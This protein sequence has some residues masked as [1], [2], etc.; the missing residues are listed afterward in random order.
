MTSTTHVEL[1]DLRV[2]A[3]TRELLAGLSL[4][5]R[6]GECVGLV[7][8]SGSGK[9]LTSLALL[10]LLP[11]GL[12][13][14]A[15]LRV[16]GQDIAFGSRQHAALRGRVFGLVPQDPL[17]ALHPLRSIGAQL[18]ETLRVA[19]GLSRDA[20]QAEAEALLRRV[21]LPQ[22]RQAMAKHPHQFSGGQRQRIAIAI[23]LATQPRI[24]IADEPTSALDARI[25]RDI[26]DLL[27]ALRR[28][29]NLGLLLISHDLPLVGAYARRLLV[30]RRG[31][32]VERGDTR[33]VFAAPSH[34]YTRELLAADQLHA[35]PAP[36]VDAPVLLRAENLRMRYRGARS[37]A[38]DGISVQL[39]RG[40]GL[41]LVGESGSGKST[42]GRALLK[43]LRGASGR[44]TLDGSAL[45][46]LDAAGLRTLRRR[47]GVV[48]QDPYASLDPRF[49][50][51]QVI[52]EPL[53][54]HG[55][56]NADSQRAKALQLLEAVGMDASALDRHPHQFSGGQR[57]RI[58][59]ARAL[60]TS[61]DLLV[62]DEAVSALDAHHR[63]SILALLAK[64]K[65]E[66]GL[67]LLF[68]THD[69]AAASAVAER[70]AVLEAGRI[71]ETG[72]T[73]AVLAHPQHAHTQALVAARPAA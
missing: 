32:V 73:A 47:I 39:R 11:A 71:V 35:L 68:V 41:A 57:Q 61:P 38:L 5:L 29:E 21:Q 52:T 62:C 7:G 33:A 43:L 67:A 36:A 8:E 28:Q 31:V 1:S 3:G 17:A 12:N 44:I 19:R 60:S 70:I 4:E 34:A 69:L 13:G 20:A 51:A 46:T 66:R 2:A 27:D 58:A 45:D 10:G 49:S 22:P 59:I 24:L 53:R 25:A 30:L 37:D 14:R 16:D 42:L 6:G 64:L 23:A 48:F 50:I 54:I 26:L 63:A 55:I 56:G 72:S 9:S 18:L 40:E 15:G 65:R